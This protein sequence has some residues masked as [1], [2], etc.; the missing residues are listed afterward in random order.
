MEPAE[1]PIRRYKYPAST[2][3]RGVVVLAPL[4]LLTAT[5]G[6]SQLVPGS[7]PDG[8]N[9][10][11]PKCTQNPQPP[12]QVH[13]Y[14]SRTFILRENP[15]A[16]FEAPFMYLLIGS[17]RA[18]LIDTGDIANPNRMPLAKPVLNLLPG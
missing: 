8:W 16:T 7:M 12:L 2:I 6:W 10:G 15:C 4:I 3:R 11:A 5:A 1:K 9:E 13:P 18:I 14:N 17:T